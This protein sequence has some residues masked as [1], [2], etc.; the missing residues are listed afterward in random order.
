MYEY[1]PS[2]PIA[3]YNRAGNCSIIHWFWL[4]DRLLISQATPFADEACE[5]I[6]IHLEEC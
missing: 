4:S 1:L 5:I 3:L 2:L 6:I